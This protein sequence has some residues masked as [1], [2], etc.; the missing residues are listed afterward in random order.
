MASSDSFPFESEWTAAVEMDAVSTEL[1]IAE[2][3][4]AE[5][6]SVCPDFGISVFS[7]AGTHEMETDVQEI[8]AFSAFSS[9]E[10]ALMETA[11]METEGETVV[12]ECASDC[13]PVLPKGDPCV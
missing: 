4:I 6:V 5:P 12:S 10:T 8:S 2:P 1:E 11:L 9:W 7:S 3:E 13:D